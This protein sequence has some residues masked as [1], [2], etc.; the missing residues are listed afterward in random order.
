MDQMAVVDIDPFSDES[1]LEPAPFQLALRTA[2]EF[3]WISKYDVWASGRYQ[4]VRDVL[5]NWSIFCSSG[6][7]GLSN[8]HKEQPWRTPSLLL[9]HDP[10]D[11]TKYR[12]IFMRAL[13]PPIIQR[14][15]AEFDR[16][17]KVQVERLLNMGS[18]DAI[19][20]L[21]ERYPLKAFG[22]VVGLTTQD[23]QLLLTYGAISFNALGPR[24]ARFLDSMSEADSVSDWIAA[25]CARSSLS[26]GS[27]GAV[28]YE[29]A[30]AGEISEG[31]AAM[32]VRSFLSAGVDTTARGLGAALHCFAL[33]PAQWKVLTRNPDLSKAAA[34][35]AIRYSSPFQTVFRTATAEYIHKSGR[36]QPGQKVLLSLG[37]ANR[38]PLKWER[39]E[40]FDITRKATGQIGFGS[41]IHACAGQMIARL[42]IEIVLGELAR[43][44]SEI[45]LDGM[46][47]YGLNNTV[48]GPSHLPVRL[49]GY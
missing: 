32:L 38:D 31:E 39:P 9:E 14:L 29:A 34:E 28:F 1:L 22:D 27:L 42:E 24:N 40:E 20:E 21:A 49:T 30:D 6:G 4:Q 2:G 15:R 45:A 47:T 18:A 44:V 35:E 23:R 10:P 8:F 36:I 13:S 12:T 46:V 19:V 37:A 33:N 16:E 25:Q 7:V 11:H 41:G 5:T 17:A 3:V 26:G 48:R 43:Q